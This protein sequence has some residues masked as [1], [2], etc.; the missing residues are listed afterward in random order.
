M[1]NVLK[2]WNTNYAIWGIVIYIYIYKHYMKTLKPFIHTC[3]VKAY[4]F[5]KKKTQYKI[6]I[7]CGP[8]LSW[9]ASR[10][11]KASV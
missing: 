9:K 5:T 8:L 2:R 6:N 10:A 4:K 1:R 11:T 7:E 3:N